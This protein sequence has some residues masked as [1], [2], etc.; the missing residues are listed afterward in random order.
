V[1]GVGM[2]A[3]SDSG[4]APVARL[5]EAG[6]AGSVLDSHNATAPPRDFISQTSCHVRKLQQPVAA[7]P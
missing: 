7:R 4:M 1:A 2:R 5:C 6:H 3:D